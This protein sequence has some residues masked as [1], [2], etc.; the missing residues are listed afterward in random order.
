[1]KIQL[2]RSNVLS[3]GAA[4]TPTASQLEYGELAVNYNNSD[5]AIFLKDS[6]NN[7]IRIS[8]VGNISDDGLTNVPDGTSPPS[9]PEAGNLWYNSDQGRLYI[10]F[11]DTD[12][13][14]WVDA[15][16]D[17][18]D[19]ST[20]PD[21]TNSS[22]QSNTLDD[23]Y[24]MVNGG[25]S[26]TGDLTI[27]DK[28]IHSADTNT[29]IR[30]PAND[31]FSVETA[32]NECLR[33]D[34]SGRV[35]IGTTS[36]DTKFDCRG[37][38]Q[39]KHENNNTSGLVSALA[40]RQGNATNGNRSSLVFNSIDNYIVAGIN[41]V[42][43]THS[44]S[45]S[46]NV[47]RLEFH[48]KASGS[49]V[50]E[51]LRIDSSGNVLIGGTLPSAPN[52]QLD[53]T[54]NASFGSSAAQRLRVVANASSTPALFLQNP[55]S[56]DYPFSVESDGSAI[57]AGTVK[58]GTF[59]GGQTT[60]DGSVLLDTGGVY[61]QITANSTSDLYRG[62][63]GSDLVFKVEDEGNAVFSGGVTSS[64]T[65]LGGVNLNPSVDDAITIYAPQGQGL[66]ATLKS[67]GSAFFSGTTGIGGTSA[68]PSIEL[69]NDGRIDAGALTV[70]SN[71]TPTSGES[72]EVFYNSGGY[73]QAYDRAN[74]AW[75][76]LRIKSSNYEIALDGSAS[77][78][79]NLTIGENTNASA[80]VNQ[81]GVFANASG[82]LN[83][84]KTDTDT[85]QFLIGYKYGQTEP[86]FKISAD[87]SASF[88]GNVGIGTTSPAHKL[89]VSEDSSSVNAELAID[90]TGSDAN[91]TAM[92]RFQRGGTNFAY[93]AGATAMLTSGN[94][95]DLGIAPVSGKNLLF[96]IGSSEKAR[97]DS[98][99]RLI[100]GRTASVASGSAA[101]SVVQI[102]GKKGSPTD[103]GQ[104]TIARGNS[105]SNLTS[106]AEIGEII[107][108]D[109]AGGNFAQ[110]Q[111]NT[112]GASGTDD[113][114]GRL[115]FH[116]TAD[117]ASS[118]TERLRIDNNGAL[119]SSHATI[120]GGLIGTN[121]N[122]LRLQSDINAN[123]TP[124]TSFYV[125]ATERMRID[126]SGQL[127][128]SGT[129]SGSNISDSII[130]FNITNS[131]G[132]QKK[133]EIKAIKTADV[134]SEL[135]FS[136]TATHNF[137]ERM[138]IDSSGN[139]KIIGTG[140]A[141]APVIE[142]E[143]DGKA[144]F[145]GGNAV[146]V[147]NGYAEIKR[148]A[149]DNGNASGIIFNRE[150]AAERYI[151]TGDD[152]DRSQPT[153]W[154]K[155]DGSASF[156][157]DITVATYDTTSATGR[158]SFLG[159]GGIVVQRPA[160]TTP[161]VPVFAALLGTTSVADIKSDG[162]AEFAGVISTTG[163]NTV[164]TASSLKVSQESANLS[165]IRAY[166]SDGSTVGSLEFRV[167]ASDGAPSYT[168]L[169]L[170]NDGSAVFS[171]SVS[172]GGTAAANTIDE[173]EEGTW[174][175]SFINA[176]TATY[177]VQAG[178]YVKIGN[179]V[180]AQFM[181]QMSSLGN[182]NT[183]TLLQVSGLP[184]TAVNTADI[185]AMSSSVHGTNW[186]I[187]QNSLNIIF[188][189]NTTIS[190]TIYSNMASAGST[191]GQLDFGDI[192]ASGNLLA[193]FTYRCA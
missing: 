123:G 81:G 185:Y 127:I 134:S 37:P 56:T 125:G 59:N 139:V 68:A 119:I 112:D 92:M 171:G 29:A 138:R 140:T 35:G 4:K 170:N 61:T 103:L 91:R 181:L 18:W 143:S 34:S 111:C 42:I 97:I 152:G 26:F 144:T 2:K 80:S 12:S 114:P 25:N 192:G 150:F 17:S 193:T 179:L 96:G 109:N 54:G 133:A 160:G 104:L 100:L 178:S 62:Y 172:I 20:Y 33:I 14:Q 77:F 86:R 102:V 99:G 78:D 122:E 106:G 51:R 108:S 27:P 131:N 157:G 174:T 161:A 22:A 93:I 189:P 187:T 168:P 36:M 5:P 191:Y 177:A 67:D 149:V 113:Y 6:N 107:F 72:I 73:I 98:S 165:Q 94:K 158:G 19:P 124:F 151:L 141:A 142:L 65:T 74:S 117:G 166:G 126:S 57:F 153:M 190:N 40:L 52:I 167:S 89:T 88:A 182:V 47:G 71:L 163:Q 70:D 116:T 31:T 30:F 101:D 1:M 49:S 184:F 132:D 129:R 55:N 50:A 87:G 180:N 28:I 44:G 162:S 156:A 137:G 45:E 105:A 15:S 121:G 32:G 147:A 69:R 24:A 136:T 95:D 58:Q 169:T 159:N 66:K 188:T 41:G 38:V 11:T 43:E 130:N 110:I 60:T 75:K 164:N 118:P 9:N 120:N 175:P 48:T 23:R 90:Y 3:S 176:G 183:S 46:N 79:G 53:S 82:F 173:Y 148:A 128:I 85:N 145:A 64:S 84:Y 16:P 186:A 8:G 39:V 63:K 135:I 146:F 154:V 76:P 10:Y 115:T 155:P 7:V 83:L 21:V 13:S